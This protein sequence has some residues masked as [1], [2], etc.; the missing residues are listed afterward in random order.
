MAMPRWIVFTSY[1][2]K[3]PTFLNVLTQYEFHFTN[4]IKPEEIRNNGS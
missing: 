1:S 4:E 2:P 3:F